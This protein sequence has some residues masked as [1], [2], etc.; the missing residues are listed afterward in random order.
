MLKL[1][2]ALCSVAPYILSATC[3]GSFKSIRT[4]TRSKLLQELNEKENQRAL[5][6]TVNFSQLKKT[7]NW[8]QNGGCFGDLFLIQ[9]LT[10][11]LSLYVSFHPALTMVSTVMYMHRVRLR[12]HD[13][14]RCSLSKS[15]LYYWEPVDRLKASQFTLG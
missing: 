5:A 10:F 14:D 15:H 12:M 1:Y 2:Y 3:F 9:T 7:M 11:P 6:K 13:R 8:P 4:A